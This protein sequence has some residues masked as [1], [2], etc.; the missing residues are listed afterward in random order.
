[1]NQSQPVLYGELFKW[2]L[3]YGLFMGLIGVT[4]FFFTN[5]M[6]PQSW[7]ARIISWLTYMGAAFVVYFALKNYKQATG[8]LTFTQ[9]FVLAFFISVISAIA[10]TAVVLLYY[11]VL[12]PE[13]LE[14]LFVKQ[15]E[16]LKLQEGI[17]PEKVQSTMEL[18]R[19]FFPYLI[20]AGSMAG[21]LFIGLLT[22]MATAFILRDQETIAAKR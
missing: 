17:T 13:A 18:T 8:N 3:N 4:G 1:M 10:I 12:N 15:E 22:G 6:D 7:P 5:S 9:G 19:K 20:F 14:K 16:R 2:A 11:Y 21:Q